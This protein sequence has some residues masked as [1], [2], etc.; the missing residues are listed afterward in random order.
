M[1]IILSTLNSRYTHSSLAL[2][3]IYANLNELKN[4]TNIL[5]FSINDALQSVA[6][7]L[8]QTYPDIIALG[9]YIW[10]ALKQKS[11]YMYLKKSHL[12]PL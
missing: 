12:R 1:K 4:N 9:T 6:E 2:R 10:N 8:L 7:K 3:Y 11:L 5:E